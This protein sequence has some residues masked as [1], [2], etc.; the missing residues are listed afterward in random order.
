MK[1]QLE[2]LSSTRRRLQVEVPPERVEAVLEGIF[3][4]LRRRA[5]IK[6]FREGRA[7]LGLVKSLYREYAHRE[8]VSRLIEQT[9]PEALKEHRLEPVTAP[10]VE[11]GLFSEKEVFVYTALVDIRPQVRLNRYKGLRIEVK[12]SKPVDDEEVLKELERMRE[13]AARVKPIREDREVKRGDWVLVDFSVY[14]EGRPVRDGRVE[15][16]LLEVG[17]GRMVPGFEEALVGM[18]PG[19]RREFSLPIPEDH[20]RSD[21]AGRQVQFKVTLKE[22][23]EKELPELDDEFAKDLGFENLEALKAK[24]RE[25]L[26]RRQK[27]AERLAL[28]QKALEELLQHNPLEVPESLLEERAAELLRR[29]EER[30]GPLS[31]QKRQEAYGQ[32]RII[33]ERELKAAY[34]IEEIAKVEGIDVEQEELEEYLKGLEIPEAL[35]GSEGFKDRARRDLLREK[36]LDFIIEEAHLEYS[37]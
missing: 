4:E 28:R 33:A 16:H 13:Y 21:L 27:Q 20:P 26:E 14:H 11:P 24:V 17:G 6:G 7:P 1:V 34:L 36:V 25:E 22:I 30:A 31:E 3:Q 2:E 19:E 15:N 8:A 37:D 23:R 10:R 12:R 29:L 32:C 35:K 5:K 9:L 18:R